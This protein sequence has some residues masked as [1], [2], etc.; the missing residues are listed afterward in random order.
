MP[1]PVPDIDAPAPFDEDRP[2]MLHV[3]Y[4]L[5][6]AGL[7]LGVPLL[8][9]AGL[10]H[11][12]AFDKSQPDWRQSHYIW[13]V[14]SFWYAVIAG[15]IGMA[16]MFTPLGMIIQIGVFVWLFYRVVKGW[17]AVPRRATMA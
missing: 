6:M 17:I 14:K 13:L 11:I 4:A 3:T 8:L 1:N 15:I 16:L 9:G 2:T 12:K 5:Y 7:L 10:A